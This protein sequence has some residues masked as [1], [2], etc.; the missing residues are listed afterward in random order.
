MF[1]NLNSYLQTG[2]VV[3]RLKA[4]TQKISSCTPLRILLPAV[5][6]TYKMLL[7]K[8]FYQRIPSLLSVFADS[9]ENTPPAHLNEAIS[10]LS[11]FFLQVLQFREDIEVNGVND[12]MAVD[13][14]GT[15]KD[16]VAVEE[17]AG[18]ALVTLVLKLSEVTFRPLYE[19]FYR[20]TEK[21]TTHTRRNITFYRYVNT[22]REIKVLTFVQLK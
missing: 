5:K 6:D 17:S 4:I 8:K 14:G 20:W 18:K 16:I 9:F 7:K 1:P 21:D 2:V 15:T 12:E 10:D 13:F 3:S 22:I 19:D 11:Q